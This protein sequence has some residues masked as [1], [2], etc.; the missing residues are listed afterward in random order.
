MGSSHPQILEDMLERHLFPGIQD[1][2]ELQTRWPTEEDAIRGGL[3][4]GF[5]SKGNF[6]PRHDD[7]SEE[8]GINSPH[9]LR[10]LNLQR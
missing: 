5:Y 6:R 7:S 2:D 3:L 1:W 8:L 10:I 9:Q 4:P